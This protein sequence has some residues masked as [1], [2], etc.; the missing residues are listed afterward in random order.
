MRGTRLAA[1][2][3]VVGL[4]VA[5]VPLGWYALSDRSEESSA[6]SLAVTTTTTTATT[7]TTTVPVTTTI[8]TTT[9]TT[10]A[11]TT[12]TLAPETTTTEATRVHAWGEAVQVNH[13]TVTAETPKEDAEAPFVDEGKKVVYCMVTIVN[14]GRE[15]YE[16]NALYFE[17]FD[18]EGQPYYSYGSTSQPELVH[19]FLLPGRK[20][21]GAVSYALPRLAE[22]ATLT[23][24]PVYGMAEQVIWGK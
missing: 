14:T 2:A 15:P 24:A 16:Y 10:V 6:T 5:G 12:T 21:K 20:I 11:A 19:G 1:V 13:L 8:P 18:A 23:F 9:S 4:L 17:M 7:T 22:A 3:F